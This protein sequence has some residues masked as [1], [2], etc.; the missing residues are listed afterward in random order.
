MASVCHDGGIDRRGGGTGRTVIP[1][2]WLVAAVMMVLC[3]IVVAPAL[4]GHMSRVEAAAIVADPVGLAARALHTGLFVGPLGIRLR[5]MWHTSTYG[6]LQIAD[7]GAVRDWRGRTGLVLRLVNGL[8]MPTPI[9][10]QRLGRNWR[11]RHRFLREDLLA[12]TRPLMGPVTYEKL[13]SALR[14]RLDEARAT[15]PSG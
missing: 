11:E 2:L 8:V 10:V 3:G 14:H 6:W 1:E 12:A 15:H 4:T 7:F 9:A 5:T 13:V